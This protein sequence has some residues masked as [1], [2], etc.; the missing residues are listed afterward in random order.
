MTL[1]RRL[2]P[3]LRPGLPSVGDPSAVGISTSMRCGPPG[4]DGLDGDPGPPGPPGVSAAITPTVP[5]TNNEA[6]AIVCGTP[7]YMF[8]AGGVKKAKASA[9]ATQIVAG[10]VLTPSIAASAIGDVALSG[11]LT[12][13]T[14][15][16]DA[17]TGQSGGLSFGV[18][19]FCSAAT[20]GLL[21]TTAPTTAA[22]FV[23][24]VGTAL[25]TTT[26]RVDIGQGILL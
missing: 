20:A 9:A 18:D 3:D 25:S 8:A 14:S 10:L 26:M 7:V 15:Q 19:Y 22:Q 12:L 2:I 1:I 16:W 23:V 6:G 17:V 24:Y 13:T 21:T 5:L 4:E 11:P